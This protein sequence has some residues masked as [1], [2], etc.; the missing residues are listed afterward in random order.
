MKRFLKQHYNFID[1]L[2]R[3]ALN[4]E[5]AGLGATA[6]H[7][8]YYAD[9]LTAYIPEQLYLL[10]IG[11]IPWSHLFDWQ[12]ETVKEAKVYDRCI[13]NERDIEKLADH[14]MIYC[15]PYRKSEFEGDI[16]API[17][18]KDNNSIKIDI[19]RNYSISFIPIK[20]DYNG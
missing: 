10:N 4:A 3:A 5:K 9:A 15:H 11:K 1:D 8:E 20:G 19:G 2:R 17:H 13:F 12:Q 14:L 16:S 6:G 7:L 18:V